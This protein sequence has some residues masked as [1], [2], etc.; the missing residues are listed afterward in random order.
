MLGKIFALLLA[1][2]IAMIAT[3]VYADGTEIHG[4]SFSTASATMH[5]E[6]KLERTFGNG[7][8]WLIASRNLGKFEIFAIITPIGPPK[9]VHNLQVNW[10]NPVKGLSNIT[11]GRT[12]PSFGNEWVRRID[13][14]PTVSY[15]GVNA[16]LVAID[17]GVSVSGDIFSRLNWTVGL[18]GGQRT[19]GNVPVSHRGE[20]DGYVRL[21]GA[22]PLEVKVGTS[23]RLGPVPAIGGALLWK[24]KN[25]TLTGEIVSSLEDNEVTAYN[26]LVEYAVTEWLH[27]VVRWEHLDKGERIFTSGFSFKPV[28]DQEVKINYIASKQNANQ[29]VEQVVLR[30]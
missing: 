14:L 4:F 18:F 24:Y 21:I 5:R 20:L 23:T 13:R 8:T 28:G 1:V 7:H 22:L 17:V 9:Y 26:Y 2:A 16:P 11:V 27:G 6:E 12:Q 25:L 10:K 30:W 3:S 15:S 29:L 19:G